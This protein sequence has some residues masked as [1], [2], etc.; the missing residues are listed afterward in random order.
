MGTPQGWYI[1]ME[2]SYPQMFNQRCRIISTKVTKQRCLQFWYHMYGM[3][4]DTLNVYIVKND[5]LGKPVWT[6]SRDQ[7]LLF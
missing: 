4:I 1:Y 7:G 6:R 3:D 5:Q 2:A